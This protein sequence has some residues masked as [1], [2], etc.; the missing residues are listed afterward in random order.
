M[1]A[2]H[3]TRGVAYSPVPHAA[4]PMLRQALRDAR[5]FGQFEVVAEALAR[6]PP[7]AQSL[8][9]RKWLDNHIPAACRLSQEYSLLLL[10]LENPPGM[11]LDMTRAGPDEEYPGQLLPRLWLC[12]SADFFVGWRPNTT[13]K[14][15]ECLCAV[16]RRPGAPQAPAAAAADSGA[17]VEAEGEALLYQPDLLLDE[18]RLEVIGKCRIHRFAQI[19]PPCSGSLV[20]TACPVPI[21]EMMF[22]HA[23]A[24]RT[25]A[26]VSLSVRLRTLAPDVTFTAYGKERGSGRGPQV[27]LLCD[28]FLA[29]CRRMPDGADVYHALWETVMPV[30]MERGRF[31]EAVQ[32]C[33]AGLALHSGRLGGAVGGLGRE[34]RAVSAFM[35]QVL[36]YRLGEVLEAQ[37]DFREAAC[38][39]AKCDV[40]VCAGDLPEELAD[41]YASSD[42]HLNALNA[43]GL[44]L[45]RAGELTE[46]AA[47]YH[48]GLSLAD[49]ESDIAEL[50]R[51][52]LEVANRGISL[53]RMVKEQ[54]PAVPNAALW[55]ML[56]AWGGKSL[57][58]DQ[59]T[60][61]ECALE[62]TQGVVPVFSRPCAHC[63]QHAEGMKRCG[64]CKAVFYCSPECQKRAWKAGHKWQCTAKHNTNEG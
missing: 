21:P 3:A 56:R 7:K 25:A 62:Q 48:R 39:Y 15:Q 47:L 18:A 61:R 37:G 40:P 9:R 5:P 19:L 4:R 12:F 49:P 42:I 33:R 57:P 41:M 51:N 28:A 36:R 13:G 1:K 22:S 60:A 8:S 24:P 6:I 63:H 31:T 43:Q 34:G 2:A 59:E 14:V 64:G 55:P 50:L 54:L 16:L 44:A 10:G 32:A 58:S 45:R 27:T 26:G 29:V 20:H 46:A 35:C 17:D 52:N 38:A 53:Q 30:L 11:V 23:D